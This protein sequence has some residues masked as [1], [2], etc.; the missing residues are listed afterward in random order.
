MNAFPMEDAHILLD[1]LSQKKVCSAFALEDGLYQI[2]LNK[3]SRPLTAVRT[4]LSFLQ[5]TRLLQS[6]K[7]FPSNFQRVTNFSLRGA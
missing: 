1:R 3:E 7:N 4:A 5:D 2:D 6:Q